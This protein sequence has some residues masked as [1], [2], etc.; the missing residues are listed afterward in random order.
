VK[1]IKFDNAEATLPLPSLIPCQYVCSI[2]NVMSFNGDVVIY[3]VYSLLL[4]KFYI[5]A[6][7]NI[8]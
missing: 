1:G 2:T 6:P 3:V 8:D 7:H 5:T 4:K